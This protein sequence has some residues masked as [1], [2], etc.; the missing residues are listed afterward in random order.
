[1]KRSIILLLSLLLSVSV[2]GCQKKQE[3]NSVK[4]KDIIAVS[5]VPQKAFVDA[6]AG[7]EFEVITMIPPGSSPESYEPTPMEIAKL[8][9]A[10]V[11]F[12]IGVPS[13]SSAI[14][15]NVKD[16]TLIVPLHEKV[17]QIYDDLTIDEGR[18]PH[19]WLS[20]KRTVVMIDEIAAAL[21][22]KYPE[23]ADKFNQSAKS[24][25]EEIMKAA[26]QI[27][28]SLNGKE[29][30]TF[31]SFHPAFNYFA[32]EFNIKM[33]SIESHGKEATP[34]ELKEIIDIAK[35]QNIKVVFTQAETDASQTKAFAEEVDAKIVSLEPL[36][37]DY[38]ENLK[39]IAEAFK[40]A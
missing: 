2:F 40:E 27:E 30:T 33:L 21:S 29:G 18:D 24:Y 35:Q 36:S 15:K 25:K 32:H 20:P 38:I 37:Y 6:V 5:I 31:I 23:K 16:T 11:Y 4:N 19:I 10:K 7:D 39:K 9:D 34:K 1:M 26:E 3:T 14:L 22:D 8:S 28:D 13:E 17:A 12:S